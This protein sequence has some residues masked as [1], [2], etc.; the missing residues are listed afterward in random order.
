MRIAAGV[1]YWA[2]VLT[3]SLALVVA[4]IYLLESQDPSSLELR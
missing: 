1:L 2:V 4:L 3:V